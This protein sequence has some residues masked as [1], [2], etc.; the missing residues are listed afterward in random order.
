MAAEL[1]GVAEEPLVA[2]L[3]AFAEARG[4]SAAQVALAWLLAQGE[5]LAPI[6]GTKH[7]ARLEENLAA[8]ALQL[9]AAQI[10]RLDAIT[11]AVGAHHDPDG[12]KLLDR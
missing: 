4:H 6:P 11:P 12:M 7:V 2:E 8:D 10:A 5:G 1:E 3:E 9:T